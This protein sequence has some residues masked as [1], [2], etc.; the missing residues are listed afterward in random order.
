MLSEINLGHSFGMSGD[1][2]PSRKVHCIREASA[3]I[4]QIP[5]GFR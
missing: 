5:G 3:G 4:S 1:S 2:D